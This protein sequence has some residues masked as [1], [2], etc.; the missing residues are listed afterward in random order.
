[1][2]LLAFQRILV[3]AGARDHGGT[4][5]APQVC[6][7]FLL[8]LCI[9]REAGA[10]RRAGGVICLD[11]DATHRAERA[12]RHAAGAGHRSHRGGLIPFDLAGETG[13]HQQQLL[14]RSDAI[15]QLLEFL[16]R[17]SID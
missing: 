17:Q 3:A 2:P 6:E 15:E 10:R 13:I 16:E 7:P 5:A 9:H 14:E 4:R 1:M 12:H 8:G 11:A